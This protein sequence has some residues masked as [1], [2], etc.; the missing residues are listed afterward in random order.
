MASGPFP[1]LFYIYIYTYIHGG[2]LQRGTPESSILIGLSIIN[3][4]FWGTSICSCGLDHSLIPYVLST[5]R[6]NQRLCCALRKVSPI[7]FSIDG[8]F[9]TEKTKFREEPE[10]AV[11]LSKRRF[12]MSQSDMRLR[13][14]A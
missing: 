13:A 12:R 6:S 11:L 8:G 3:N 7:A 1:A 4:A 2:F 10:T 14:S 9:E 5:N